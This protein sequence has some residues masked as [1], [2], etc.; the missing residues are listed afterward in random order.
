M[1]K[2]Q[3]EKWENKVSEDQLDSDGQE[4]ESLDEFDEMLEVRMN[5]IQ[6]PGLTYD[7]ENKDGGCR[8]GKLKSIN[9]QQFQPGLFMLLYLRR[10]SISSFR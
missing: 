8:V 3:E 6:N 7:S 9:T 4:L 2:I 1:S 10:Y 5:K